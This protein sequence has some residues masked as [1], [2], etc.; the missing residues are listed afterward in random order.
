MPLLPFH[1]ATVPLPI[2]ITRIEA[3]AGTGKTYTLTALFLRLVVEENLPVNSILV[4]TFTIAA[5][6]E[7][8]DRIRS[9]LHLALSLFTQTPTEDAL[10]EEL[11]DSYLANAST[12]RPRLEAALR[13]FDDASISTIHGFC[14]RLLQ[15]RAFESSQAFDAELL[16]DSQPLLQEVA[17]DFWRTQF[18]PAPPRLAAFAINRHLSA[19]SL[20]NLLAKISSHPTLEILP[21]YRLTHLASSQA[22]LLTAFD[23]L[24]KTW[25]DG[26]P[27]LREIFA[28]ANAWAKAESTLRKIITNSKKWSDGKLTTLILDSL[29]HCFQNPHAQPADYLALVAFTT[30]NLIACTK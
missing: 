27:T 29:D 21:P 3:S 5:T 18:Y 14:Q 12:Y 24:Q 30:E 28:D 20:V 2:G 25:T 17:D 4:T 7:L 6:A 13:Q 9:R 15:E 16:T 11:R 22:T 23:N 19:S 8:R 26:E 10:L 1:L